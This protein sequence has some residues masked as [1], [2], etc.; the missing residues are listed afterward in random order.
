MA[1]GNHTPNDIEN[2][3]PTP[4]VTLL[5]SELDA[6]PPLSSMCCIYRVS[7]R[8]RLGKDR[9]YTPQVVSI[10]P[11]HH[12]KEELKPME[13]HKKRYLVDL[14]KRTNKSLE[15]YIEMIKQKEELLRSCYAESIG[16]TGDEFVKII[17]VDAAFIIEVLLRY[18]QKLKDEHDR[19]FNKPWMLQDIWHDLRLLENQLP[20]FILKEILDT[21][22]SSDGRR[23]SILDLSYTFFKDI[24]NIEGTE[25][26]LRRLESSDVAHFVDFLRSLYVPLSGSGG[27]I[28]TLTIPRM[29][30]LH[31]AG[32]KFKV[33]SSGNLF[34]L[35]FSKGVLEIPKLTISDETEITIRNLLAFEQCHC[36]ENYLNDY[37]VM[38]DCLVDTPKDVDLLVKYGIVEN[39]LGDNA[40]GSTLI[41]KLADGVTV[42]YKNFYFAKISEELNDYYRTSWHRW[43]AN[44]KQNYFNTPWATV[45]VI[46][47]I[48]LIILTIIQAVCS[49]ISVIRKD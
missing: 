49:V 47:A 2:P 25:D 36:T 22:S 13:E 9:A 39:R 14:L 4:F 28:N 6:L 38:M 37:V 15:D 40:E 44:L 19:I 24:M 34:D 41:N 1:N 32:V 26:K 17:L 3:P 21:V 12:G 35:Q 33:G 23:L 43:K 42:E 27:T 48:L 7:E 10:G 5:R 11:I 45:S 46:A 18:P 31:R 20:F 29:T 8:L 30:E 16:F